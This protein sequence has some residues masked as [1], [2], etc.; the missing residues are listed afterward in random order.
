MT[1]SPRVHGVGRRV[2]LVLLAVA[3]AAGA[4]QLSART[5]LPLPALA[6]WEARH[7]DPRPLQPAEV[8]QFAALRDSERAT[9]LVWWLGALAAGCLALA[10]RPELAERAGGTPMAVLIAG[11]LGLGLFA[12]GASLRSQWLAA[13]HGEWDL[14]DAALV[15]AAGPR[16]ADV[17]DFRSAIAEG[18]AVVLLGS[19]GPLWNLAAWTLFPRPVF[20]L[21]G[22]VPSGLSEGELHAAIAAL[23]LGHAGR[24]WLLDVDAWR[25]GETATRP[26]LVE[27]SR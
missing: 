3:C 23:D 1:G 12:L 16:A 8:A 6:S 14:S 13:R 11:S 19:D 9:D 17:L 25:A 21:V 18:D 7:P 5:T 24:R 15:A 26:V 10:W 4:L 20:P 27:L 22:S 2:L